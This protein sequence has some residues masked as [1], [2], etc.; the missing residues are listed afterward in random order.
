MLTHAGTHALLMLENTV[1]HE[2][3][4]QLVATSFTYKIRNGEKQENSECG[5]IGVSVSKH[6]GYSTVF[7][8]TSQHL[9]EIVLT[10]L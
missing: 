6:F 5:F 2:Q 3:E 7:S 4:N 9:R 1:I 10:C 8:V